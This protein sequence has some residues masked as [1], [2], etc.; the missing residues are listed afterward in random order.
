MHKNA[1]REDYVEAYRF[2]CQ[3]PAKNVYRATGVRGNGKAPQGVRNQTLRFLTPSGPFSLSACAHVHRA[4]GGVGNGKAPRICMGPFPAAPSIISITERSPPASSTTIRYAR[5]GA[6][7]G[8]QFDVS[9]YL[10][11]ERLESEGPLVA[12]AFDLKRVVALQQR[13]RRPASRVCSRSTLQ[14]RRA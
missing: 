6:G 11:I 4:T 9:R 13:D 5:L 10:D 1:A 14:A 8:N 7:Q 2:E 12:A 3:Y